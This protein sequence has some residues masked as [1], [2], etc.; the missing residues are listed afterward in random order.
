MWVYTL[1]HKSEVLQKFTEWKRLVEKSSGLKLKTL[2]TDNGG[3]YNS[4]E[5]SDYCRREGI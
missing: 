5:F 1:K 4:T 3:E 2:R